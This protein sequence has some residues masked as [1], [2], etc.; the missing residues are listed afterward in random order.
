MT[1]IKKIVIYTLLTFLRESFDDPHDRF[2]PRLSGREKILGHNSTSIKIK[3]IIVHKTFELRMNKERKSL[4]F[5]LTEILALTKP[6][7]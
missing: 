5:L 6:D 7:P 2:P 1:M 4:L 3:S